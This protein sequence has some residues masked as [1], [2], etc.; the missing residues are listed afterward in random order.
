M[1]CGLDAGSR[2]I[3]LIT[4]SQVGDQ[5]PSSAGGESTADHS[6]MSL[7]EEGGPQPKIVARALGVTM[8]GHSR[9]P[10]P[11]RPSLRS[12]PATPIS[13]APALSSTSFPTTAGLDSPPQHSE[14]GRLRRT[15]PKG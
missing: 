8:V 10:P 13:A 7:Y 15:C 12:R 9:M 11:M 1:G 3:A 4:G 6:L 2:G 14:L 5:G